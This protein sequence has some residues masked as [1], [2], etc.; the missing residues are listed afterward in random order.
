MALTTLGGTTSTTR[1]TGVA[2]SSSSQTSSKSGTVSADITNLLE[3]GASYD[4][5]MS[6]NLAIIADIPT[7]LWSLGTSMP[8]QRGCGIVWYRVEALSVRR[9]P[10]LWLQMIRS[11]R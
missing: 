6:V 4:D 9:R 8:L 11:S 7:P 2:T 5:L 1:D 10:P 3:T